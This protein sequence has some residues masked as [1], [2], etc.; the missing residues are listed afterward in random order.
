[1]VF[2]S[3]AR[4]RDGLRHL[5]AQRVR[6]AHEDS[7]NL[8]FRFRGGDQRRHAI[9]VGRQ[10]I[11]Y[12]RGPMRRILPALVAWISLPE[13]SSYSNCAVFALNVSLTARARK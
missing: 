2:P 7:V 8:R 5:A 11:A 9:R 13:R 6:F 4:V 12:D 3:V 10:R 1:M